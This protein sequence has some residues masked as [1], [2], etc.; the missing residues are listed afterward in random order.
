MKDHRPPSALQ[1]LR[2][3]RLTLFALFCT[4]GILFLA[5]MGLSYIY[6][7]ALTRPGCPEDR[8]QPTDYGLT[9]FRSVEFS[10]ADAVALSGWFV[11]SQNGATIILLGG[12]GTRSAMLPEAA[13]LARHGYGLLLFDWRGC[14]ADQANLHTL[15]YQETLDVMA[16]T[17]FLLSESNAE[18]LG[19]LGFSLGGAAAIR[20]AALHPG[21]AAV[22]A[23]GNY[24]DLEAEIRGAGDE[25]PVLSSVFENQITW[26]FQQQTGVSFAEESEP[27]EL[28]ARI[29]PRPVLLIFG[30]LEESLPPPSGHLLYQAAGEPR[31]LWIIPRVGHGG[32]FQAE[33]AEF[34]R[35][36]TSFFNSALLH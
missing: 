36:V 34:E 11:P 12:R 22:V 32:Y 30:E 33:P 26:L 9:Q 14:G 1:L 20:A 31:E 16:A 24:H 25:H 29:S 8:Q 7:Q 13:M 23:M 18:Q 19:V 2:F 5:S 6:L 4:A 21:I 35:R 27:V 15:G 10:T 3:A 17:D 28:L